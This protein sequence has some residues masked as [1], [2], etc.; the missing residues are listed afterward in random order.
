VV[1]VGVFT[2]AVF[3]PH[4]VIRNTVRQ[5]AKEHGVAVA[6][7]ARGLG[8]ALSEKVIHARSEVG[9]V[10]QSWNGC[11][12]RKS[13]VFGGCSNR[14]NQNGLLLSGNMATGLQSLLYKT[15]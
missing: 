8:G 6:D 14:S 12:A 3:L 13:A 7:F 11:E 5:I 15:L 9:T 1:E 2:G 4:G 10:F